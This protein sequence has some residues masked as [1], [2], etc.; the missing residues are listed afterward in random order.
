M[1]LLI[2]FVAAGRQALRAQ[3][4]AAGGKREEKNGRERGLFGGSFAAQF[5][6]ARFGCI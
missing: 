6:E 1:H 4:A 2:G 5:Q 3:A